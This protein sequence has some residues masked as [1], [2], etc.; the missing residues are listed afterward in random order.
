M[1]EGAGPFAL[2]EPE[3]RAVADFAGQHP[4]IFA[5]LD[6][7]TYGGV[8]IRP[9]GTAPDETMD[10]EDLALWHELGAQCEALTDYPMVNGFTEFT[11]DPGKPLCGDLTEF[12]YYTR[13][14]LAYVCEL[15]DLFAQLGMRRTPRFVDQYFRF[16]RDLMH[17]L[18]RWDIKHNRGR[19][20][21]PWVPVEHPQ[22]GPVE[23]G[24][25]DLRFG[26]RNP[27]PER[28]PEIAQA[29]SAAF[30]RVAAMAPRLWAS[31]LRATPYG[32]S[33]WQLELIVEN[34][35]YLGTGVVPSL[36]AHAWNEAPRAWAQADEGA[37]LLDE[38][39]GQRTLGHLAGWG[40]GRHGSFGSPGF[41]RGCGRTSSQRLRWIAR[42]PGRV[43]VRV[44][45]GRVGWIERELRLDPAAHSQGEVPPGS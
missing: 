10:P 37:A 45:S 33:L 3:S 12:A 26:L 36:S 19:I 34:R 27:P 9:S 32:A 44:G 1:Q 5:W 28:L 22:L 25:V 24:G 4:N 30:L 31:P 38:R 17:R 23:V 2:S 18:A 39:E 21:R 6:L 11:Y 8:F 41:Y 15:W 43:R 20:F 13:G 35:G 29:Q 7:H 40:R 16:D 42:G 14:A